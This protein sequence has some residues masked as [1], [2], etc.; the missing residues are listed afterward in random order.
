MML[1]E[2]ECVLFDYFEQ[3]DRVVLDISIV[4][5]L[6]NL[7]L[8]SLGAMFPKERVHLDLVLLVGGALIAELLPVVLEF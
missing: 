5:A 8:H 4:G 1:L 2:V 7:V 3:L 6:L